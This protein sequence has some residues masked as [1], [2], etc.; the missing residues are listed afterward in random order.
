MTKIEPRLRTK[1]QTAL[2]DDVRLIVRVEGEMSAA[3]ARLAELGVTVLRSFRLIHAVAVRCSGEQ[4][5]ALLQEP[6]VRLIE[7]DR[8]VSV[9]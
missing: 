9:Q 3:S 1:L 2:L 8:Q 7:E 5:L 4:A 6:C